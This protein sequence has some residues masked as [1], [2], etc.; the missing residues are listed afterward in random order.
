MNNRRINTRN[1]ISAMCDRSTTIN[2]V[3][4]QGPR[5]VS[6]LVPNSIKRW[7]CT[8]YTSPESA[9]LNNGFST[10]YYNSQEG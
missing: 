4:D 7:V 8:F 9:V 10:N 2:H 1:Y 6:G 5:G 3:P